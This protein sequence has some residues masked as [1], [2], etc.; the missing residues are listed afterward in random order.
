MLKRPVVLV[1]MVF[2][3]A[4]TV[5]LVRTHFRRRAL[6]E[7]AK[8]I[9]PEMMAAAFHD[10]APPCLRYLT[11][12]DDA[13]EAEFEETAK[14]LDAV[15]LSSEQ[16]TDV[17]GHFITEHQKRETR[18]HLATSVDEYLEQLKEQQ[19]DPVSRIA[20]WTQRELLRAKLSKVVDGAANTLS[21]LEAEGAV[22]WA[23]LTPAQRATLQTIDTE[24]P[25][26]LEVSGLIRVLKPLKTLTTHRRAKVIA[27]LARDATLKRPESEV[28]LEDLAL[29]APKRI[30]AFGNAFVL[31]VA[32][33]LIEVRS[34]GPDDSSLDDDIIETADLSEPRKP[35][36]LR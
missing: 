21:T 29:P 15:G 7:N 1:L 5:A 2:A 8:A 4:T 28:R 18:A 17:V 35:G 34:P 36:M 32:T 27:E 33:G 3:I 31:S 6:T 26:H 14:R 30:D 13:P 23:S 24:H 11:S 19:L 16:L 12:L 22:V 25:L 10:G 9:E 20:F